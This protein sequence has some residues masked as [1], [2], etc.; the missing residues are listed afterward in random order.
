[1]NQLYIFVLLSTLL[2]NLLTAC[3]GGSEPQS[4][5]TQATLGADENQPSN[6]SE[7]VQSQPV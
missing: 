3:G 2:S 5:T 6:I 7:P 4:N 1:M